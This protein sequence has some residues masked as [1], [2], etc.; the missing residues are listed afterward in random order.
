MQ[1]QVADALQRDGFFHARALAPAEYLAV[2]ASLG[3][4]VAVDDVELRPGVGSYACSP[5]SVPFHTDHPA[6][7]IAAWCCIRQDPVDGASLLLDSQPLIRALSPRH[8]TSLESLRLAFPPLA[9]GHAAGAAPV[10]VQRADRHEVYYPPIVRPDQPGLE[11]LAALQTLV[12][13]VREVGPSA[14]IQIRL[15]VNDAL[16]VD[17]R[18]MLHGRGPLRPDSPRLL[19]RVWMRRG[20]LPA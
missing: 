13:R 7:A 2:S 5:G 20:M 16:F 1:Q 6:I 12:E 11:A 10:L 15:D 9:V 18:R 17:N 14:Q 3:E 19:R 4:V 8:V